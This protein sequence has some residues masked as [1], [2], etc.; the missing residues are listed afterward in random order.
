MLS[1]HFLEKKQKLFLHGIAIDYKHLKTANKSTVKFIVLSLTGAQKKW[2]Q[3][4][5]RQ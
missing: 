5:K 2:R 4:L 1:G 3:L